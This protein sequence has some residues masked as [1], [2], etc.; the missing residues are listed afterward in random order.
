MQ[1]ALLLILL[2]RDR[3]FWDYPRF[4]C[5]REHLLDLFGCEGILI[6]V[7]SSGCACEITDRR[8]AKSTSRKKKNEES[9]TSRR[10]GIPNIIIGD[11]CIGHLASSVSLVRQGASI[12]RQENLNAGRSRRRSILYCLDLIASIGKKP[13]SA[14]LLESRISQKQRSLIHN[15]EHLSENLVNRERYFSLQLYIF[16]KNYS[17]IL[18]TEH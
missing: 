6:S 17:K 18:E 2:L 12:R 13:D 16:N 3:A 10:R 1:E 7:R 15:S 5:L 14:R 4:T 9:G 11:A 8:E